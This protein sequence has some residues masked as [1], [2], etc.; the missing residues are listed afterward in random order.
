MSQCR[1]K[2][3]K[4]CHIILTLRKSGGIIFLTIRGVSLK[5]RRNKMQTYDENLLRDTLEFIR[6]YQE[7]E[8]RS[9]SYRTI[10]HGVNGITSLARVQR[11]LKVLDERGLIEKTQNIGIEIPTTH[12]AGRCEA[13]Q[14]VGAVACGT[15]ILAYENVEGTYMLPTELYGGG[16]KFLLRAKGNSMVEKNIHNGDLIVVRKQNNADPGQV[17]IAMIGDEATAKIFL[18]QKNK[19]ILRAANS[20]VDEN[21]ERVYKDIE[22]KNC[23][24]LGVVVGYLGKI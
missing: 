21:G 22:T 11:Y 1:D 6:K 13:A 3:K 5:H 12:E 19:V 16:E 10:L 14:L 8:G 9:P 2:S 7:V 18:P 4:A 17:V 20:K 15:P 24:I 23:E